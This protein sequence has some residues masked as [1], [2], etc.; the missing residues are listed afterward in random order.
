MSRLV[1]SLAPLVRSPVERVPKPPEVTRSANQAAVRL[2]ATA[3]KCLVRGEIDGLA[4]LLYQAASRG[5]LEA[6]VR[7]GTLYIIGEGV[8]KDIGAAAACFRLAAAAQDGVGYVATGEGVR[9]A[10]G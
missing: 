7:L 10:A 8:P 1:P 2:Y 3:L 9:L 5:H 6:M 4:E